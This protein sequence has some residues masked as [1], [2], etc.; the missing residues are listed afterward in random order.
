MYGRT[1]VRPLLLAIEH[2]KGGKKGFT[3]IVFV[4]P[5]ARPDQRSMRKFRRTN[6]KISHTKSQRKM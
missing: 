2:G 1:T 4:G 3:R 6:S 5:D